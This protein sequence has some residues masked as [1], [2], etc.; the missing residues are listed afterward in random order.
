M[1]RVVI[2]SATNGLTV[3]RAIKTTAASCADVSHKSAGKVPGKVILL[4]QMLSYSICKKEN[5][6]NY[7]VILLKIPIFFITTESVSY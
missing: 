6:K 7:T 1:Q 2:G 5:N 3:T 4:C